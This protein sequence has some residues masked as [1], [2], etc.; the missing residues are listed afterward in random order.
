MPSEEITE[1]VVHA[2]KERGLLLPD[3]V[4]KLNAKIAAGTMKAEDWWLAADKAVVE[5]ANQ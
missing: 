5:E 4:D 2:I 1:A 3:D